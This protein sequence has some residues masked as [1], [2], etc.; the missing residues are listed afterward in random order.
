VTI[1]QFTEN[2]Y[3]CNQTDIEY[4]MDV[5]PQFY[6]VNT[7]FISLKVELSDGLQTAVD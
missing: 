5:I 3:F 6:G 7:S 4:Y 1:Q 2:S